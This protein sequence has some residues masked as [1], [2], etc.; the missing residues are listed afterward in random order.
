MSTKTVAD[1]DAIINRH[2][3]AMMEEL[4]EGGYGVLA[5]LACVV[6]EG[7]TEE[8]FDTNIATGLLKPIFDI[9]DDSP[10]AQSAELIAF[11]WATIEKTLKQMRMS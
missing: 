5:V 11:A 2:L 1:A 4:H 6:G 10:D 8:T 3:H 7:D 9:D